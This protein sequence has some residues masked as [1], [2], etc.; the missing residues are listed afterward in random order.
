MIPIRLRAPLRS[1]HE[2]VLVPVKMF[3]FRHSVVYR[4]LY[5]LSR[6]LFSSSCKVWLHFIL[7]IFKETIVRVWNHLFT[8][9]LQIS[10]SSYFLCLT[11]INF[12]R[13][14]TAKSTHFQ[15][16]L[17]IVTEPEEFIGKSSRI[18]KT[19]NFVIHLL[20]Y[21]SHFLNMRTS[22]PKYFLQ[23]H[24]C[25]RKLSSLWPCNFERLSSLVFPFVEYFRLSF[26]LD[27]GS[28]GFLLI[29]VACTTMK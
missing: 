9:F 1:G 13:K 23:Y 3:G 29:I 19:T 6:S 17:Y 14:L 20:L 21:L 22:V 18:L 27:F 16:L 11:G 4:S 8:H 2:Y 24:Q 5:F 28:S 15:A 26:S 25:A 10:N 12:N 7:E